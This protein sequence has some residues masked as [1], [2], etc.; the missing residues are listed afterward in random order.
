MR[1]HTLPF[2]HRKREGILRSIQKYSLYLEYSSPSCYFYGLHHIFILFFGTKREK[3]GTNFADSFRALLYK[4]G[5][6]PDPL[7]KGKKNVSS[8]VF[9]FLKS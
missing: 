3:R 2:Y 7:R 4:N 1:S 5:S 8:S 6:P 9:L